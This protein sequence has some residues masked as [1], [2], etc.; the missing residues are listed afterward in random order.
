MY[1]RLC[2]TVKSSGKL[3][4][5]ES[6]IYGFIEQYGPDKDWYISIYDYNDEQ[7]EKFEQ[8]NQRKAITM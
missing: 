4:P 3:I 2:R 8:Q 5:K 7:F 1:K 6:E